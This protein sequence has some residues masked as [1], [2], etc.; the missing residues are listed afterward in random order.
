M[1][2]EFCQR[3]ITSLSMRS[4]PGGEAGTCAFR[5]CQCG[6][7]VGLLVGVMAYVA[8]ESPFNDSNT[9]LREREA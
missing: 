2:H 6:L 7:S 1:A 9:G 5:G 4:V 8:L 3:G